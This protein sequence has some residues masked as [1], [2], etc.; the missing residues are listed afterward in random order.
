M[1]AM[2]ARLDLTVAERRLPKRR[3]RF[4]AIAGAPATESGLLVPT[5]GVRCVPAT[6]PWMI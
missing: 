6:Y 5:L 2:K 3:S 1:A 4:E